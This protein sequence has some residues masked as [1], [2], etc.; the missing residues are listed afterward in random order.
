MLIF[1]NYVCVCHRCSGRWGCAADAAGVKD[2]KGS[3]SALAEGQE[4]EASGGLCNSVVWVQQ[5]L[6]QRQKTA[7]LWVYHL[8]LNY[9]LK[10]ISKLRFQH[11]ICEFRN[12][13]ARWARV[14]SVSALSWGLFSKIFCFYI[15]CLPPYISTM[16]HFFVSYES[17]R[18][19]KQFCIVGIKFSKDS[20]L[21][22]VLSYELVLTRGYFHAE[23]EGG[24]IDC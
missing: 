12:D 22:K 3:I 17:H 8:W 14:G 13:V 18:N 23:R 21:H 20:I 10:Q 5:N 11:S 19:K 6:P 7:D 2:D 24:R 16:D 15:L 1:L 4:P 9:I